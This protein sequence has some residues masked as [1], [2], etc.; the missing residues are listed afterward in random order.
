MDPFVDHSTA[1]LLEVVDARA[2][3]VRCAKSGDA[4]A[5][6]QLARLLDLEGASSDLA[7]AIEAAV[8]IA[9]GVNK[10]RLMLAQAQ[11]YFESGRLDVC[12][13]AIRQCRE[14]SE[15]PEVQ[16]V[17]TAI[18]ARLSD[19]MEEAESLLRQANMQYAQ[20]ENQNDV[21]LGFLSS[22]QGHLAIRRNERAAARTFCERATNL[23]LKA[24]AKHLASVAAGILGNLEFDDGHLASALDW[25]T[26]AAE[27]GAESRMQTSQ[28]IF[29]GYRAWVLQMMGETISA[30]QEYKTAV[31]QCAAIG[32]IRFESMFRA[33]RA[34][35]PAHEE[36]TARRELAF[37]TALGTLAQTGDESRASAIEHLVEL[38]ECERVADATTPEEQA[39]RLIRIRARALKRPLD[40]DDARVARRMVDAS[41]QASLPETCEANFTA[42][43]A[44]LQQ[45]RGP[46]GNKSLANHP[47]LQRLLWRLAVAWAN[48]ETASDQELVAIG[49]PDEQLIPESAQRRLQVAISTLRKSALGE[50]LVREAGSY[51]LRGPLAI[52]RARN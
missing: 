1:S 6:V 41:W 52:V 33:L 23:A 21:I 28:A 39:R 5:A 14:Q 15:M 44:E 4:A 8:K 36:S 32:D 34:T 38:F 48:S 27:L 31:E 17:A 10:E 9:N 46:A 25:F 35:L 16:A 37:R 51:C 45:V 20:C 22:A 40:S 3:Y 30:T 18:A 49:W 19:D 13:R 24:G 47:A 29:T 50:R 43:D 11:V 42:I 7:Q 26:Q 12:A 2:E